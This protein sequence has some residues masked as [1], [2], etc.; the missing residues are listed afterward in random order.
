MS[1]APIFGFDDDEPQEVN[2][3]SPSDDN[4]IML[5]EDDESSGSHHSTSKPKE[6]KKKK[7]Q[8]VTRKEFLSL[9]AK[10]D[11]ILAAV[12]PNQLQPEDSPGP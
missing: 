7:K 9:Q 1:S 5:D 11:Q 12:K 8:V 10:V 3:P 4:L 6:K 2:K